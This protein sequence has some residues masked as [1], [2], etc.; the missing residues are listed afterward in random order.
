AADL[1][2]VRRPGHFAGV[3][4]V[5]A[6][7]F[8]I[9]QPDS[10]CFGQKDFQQLRVIQAMVEDLNFPLRVIPCPTKR[11]PDGLAMSSRNVY[12]ST[13]A[14]KHALGLSKALAEAR[15]LVEREGETDPAAVE[16]AMERTMAAHQV[17]VDYAAVRHPLT[18]A[19]LDCIEPAV[20][21]GVAALV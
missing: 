7:L 15:E 16:A 3:C 17:K 18:L 11:E 1:E 5:V 10:A 6:K 12:L 19:R 20:T 9:V 14:R 2:G 8:H 4:R 13:Q 21:R